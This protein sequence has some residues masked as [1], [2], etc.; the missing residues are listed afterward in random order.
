MR[1]MGTF[2]HQKRRIMGWGWKGYMIVVFKPL[3]GCHKEEG[4]LF[5]LAAE[6]RHKA[7]V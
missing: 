5:C 6:G 4:Q 7:V 2:S 3:K 1:E